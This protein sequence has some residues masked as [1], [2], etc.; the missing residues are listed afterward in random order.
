MV[1]RQAWWVIENADASG[2]KYKCGVF[3]FKIMFL[4]DPGRLTGGLQGAN[5][6]NSSQKRDLELQASLLA[7]FLVFAAPQHAS[8]QHWL[9][10]RFLVTSNCFCVCFCT[11][12]VFSSE[13]HVHFGTPRLATAFPGH[14]G[15]TVFP[16][17]PTLA[18]GSAPHC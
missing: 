11:S 6:P 10:Q 17:Y 13:G 16:P 15:A 4:K 9:S 5:S 3:I 2:A 12:T 14:L 7:E 8:A 18:Y 1:C